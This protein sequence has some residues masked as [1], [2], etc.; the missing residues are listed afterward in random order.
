MSCLKFWGLLKSN[1][2][3]WYDDVLHPFSKEANIKCLNNKTNVK[4]ASTQEGFLESLKD[5]GPDKCPWMVGE[6]FMTDGVQVKMLLVT[7]EHKR[8]TF[9]V[10]MN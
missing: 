2:A 1:D 8:E 10:P 9:Q 3:W 6:S 7:I 4:Y 5:D